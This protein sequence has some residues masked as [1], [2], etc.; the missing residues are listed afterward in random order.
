[1]ATCNIGCA[2]YLKH[3]PSFPTHSCN[4]AFECRISILL[5]MY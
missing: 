1:M 3:L 2:S 4:Q 5:L